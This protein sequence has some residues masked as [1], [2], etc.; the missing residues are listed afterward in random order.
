MELLFEV[1]ELAAVPGLEL[2]L[3]VET[4]GNAAVAGLAFALWEVW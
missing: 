1:E 2:L 4:R 3:G